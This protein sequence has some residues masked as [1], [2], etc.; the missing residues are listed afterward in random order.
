MQRLLVCALWGI[1]TSAGCVS[2]QEKLRFSSFVAPGLTPVAEKIL[3]QAYA[4]LG[5]QIETVI[6]NPRRALLDAASGKTDGELVRVEGVSDRHKTLIRVD[7]PVVVARI[8]AFTRNPQLQGKSLSELKYLRAGHV[9]G[10]RFAG[11]L[12]EGFLEVW[13]AEEPEQLFEMLLRDRIDVVVVGEDTGNRLIR[14]MG[15][16]DVYPLQP[17]LGEIAFYH[18][19]HVKHADLVPLIED[20]LRRRLEDAE[21]DE[22]EDSTR[23]EPSLNELTRL[24]L[25]MS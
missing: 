10:A 5:I 23:R 12:A 21:G 1:L 17:S 6:S 19:L 2:A 15:L 24:K 22:Q 11:E 7:V 20:V 3:S 4:E 14:E 25:G 8:F 13:T 16:T 18:F 9:G